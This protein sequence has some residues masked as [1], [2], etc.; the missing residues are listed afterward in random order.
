MILEVLYNEVLKRERFKR[1]E[2]MEW[3]LKSAEVF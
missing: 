2:R 3:R 1:G